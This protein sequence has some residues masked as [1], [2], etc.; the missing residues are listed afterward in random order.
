MKHKKK[1]G[2][3]FSTMLR[4]I[5]EKK[6]DVFI[7]NYVVAV[8]AGAF[9]GGAVIFLQNVLD[10]VTAYAAKEAE[11]GAVLRAFVIFLLIK[12]GDQVCTGVYNTLGETHSEI[13][14]R[15]LGNR[16]HQKIARTEAVRFEEKER[17]LA[18]Q[19]AYRGAQNGRN[20][21]NT[22]LT[23]LFLYIPYYGILS[24]FLFLQEPIL[25]LLLF[26]ILLP[27]IFSQVLKSRSFAAMEKKTAQADREMRYMTRCIGSKEAFAETRQLGA[28]PYFK[29]CLAQSIHGFNLAKKEAYRAA[30]W[31]DFIM[32]AG[33]LLAY[34]GVIL[35]LFRALVS[36]QISFGAF[37][38]MFCSLDSIY[39]MTQEV[40]LE[41]VSY[42]VELKESIRN[43]VR[44]LRGE[45]KEQ[46]DGQ[47]DRHGEIVCSHVSFKYPG[48]TEEALTDVN[49]TLREGET[50]AVV[51]ENGSGKTTLARLLLGI[52]LPDSGTVSHNGVP[53][54]AYRRAALYQK[55]TAVFQCFGRYRMTLEENITISDGKADRLDREEGGEG[56]DDRI[57]TA[58][59]R[60]GLEQNGNVGQ[61]LFPQGEKTML[62]NEFGGVDLSGGQWQRVAI[63]RGFY[64]E[65]ELIVLDEPTAA[66]D[67]IE[68]KEILTRFLELAAD[69]TAVIIT[70]RLA[71]VRRADRIAVMSGS[72][73][74]ACDMHERLLESCELYRRMWEAQAGQYV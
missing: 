18:I 45:E 43:F 14:I 55:S 30:A 65:H 33:S 52:Y 6:K 50:L 49:L 61:A 58:L 74:I 4:L 67:P 12:L 8:M 10:A 56:G 21:V 11:L 48:S 9:A 7:W 73:L 51:G 27:G 57:R 69:K 34:A 53:V 71:S 22:Y 60:A 32:G 41:T 16:I 68:E 70:H 36:G 44:F 39:E 62:G 1:D 66:I 15:N 24:A 2:I 54:Q 40:I 64:R 46:G 25:C 63:A 37:G 35:V 20:Y 47:L 23:L 13:S 19:K 5:S 17:L 42:S 3:L 31:L 28:F 72:R 59:E 26:L 29:E 38:A